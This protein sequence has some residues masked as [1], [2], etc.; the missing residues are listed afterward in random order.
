MESSRR[1]FDRPSLHFFA[2]SF[3]AVVLFLSEVYF[4]SRQ[5]GC[6]AQRAV[7]I[8]LRCDTDIALILDERPDRGVG[9]RVGRTPAQLA[10]AATASG[11]LFGFDNFRYVALGQFAA[12]F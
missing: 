6:P 1:S 3:A 7:D 12:G 9:L 5:S 4:S 2:I 8:A 10:R 11:C